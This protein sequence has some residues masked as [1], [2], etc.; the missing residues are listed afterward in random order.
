MIEN[1]SQDVP[2]C[3]GRDND[4][5]YF[6]SHSSYKILKFSAS[7]ITKANLFE[8]AP[9]QFWAESF[10]TNSKK[11]NAFD[12]DEAL[13]WLIQE[14][15]KSSFFSAKNLYGTGF[16]RDG[17]KLFFNT[18]ESVYFWGPEKLFS[19]D[20]NKILKY[21]YVK[22]LSDSD[23]NKTFLEGELVDIDI[24][25]S[26]ATQDQCQSLF[27]LIQKLSFENQ[28]SAHLLAGWIF[29][30]QVT[31]AMAWRP[32]IWVTGPAGS[33][34]TTI[35]RDILIP[36]I[37]HKKQFLGKTTEA[38][39]RQTI[40]ADSC[41]VFF[42]EAES[43]DKI[44]AQRVQNII[45]LVRASSSDSEAAIIKG[46]PSGSSIEYYPRF[47][48]CLSS[49]NTNLATEQDRSRFTLIELVKNPNNDF[50]TKTK[51]D[52]EKMINKDFANA[53]ALRSID[54]FRIFTLNFKKLY[55]LIMK[56]VSAR[57]ADQI[58]T[59]AAG[60]LAL[61]QDEIVRDPK[62]FLEAH[63]YFLPKQKVTLEDSNEMECLGH[64]LSSSVNDT[65]TM[66]TI[67]RLLYFVYQND[68][69]RDFAE[70]LLET[71][72]L[73]FNENDDAFLVATNHAQLAKIF[74]GTQ[75][76]KWGSS[77]SRIEGAKYTTTRIYGRVVCAVKIPFACVI[78]R[79]GDD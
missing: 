50:M 53:L 29:T 25:Q 5:Y 20:T 52:F 22:N 63:N 79:G 49:I 23:S 31:G 9:L 40:K 39:I 76:I 61:I 67:Q 55:P 58:G 77:L 71:L 54:N 21:K 68:G 30:A 73:K 66:Y 35:L 24:N 46:S 26:P 45:E 42:D 59:L 57:F 13:N 64:L 41:A 44:S 12:L 36:L 51:F 47:Q 33:G 38:G 17:Q 8:L 27:E 19:A 65:G 43:F 62:S 78:N 34:K 75:W 1:Q 28:S 6:R 14:G 72:G 15:K 11:I 74:A 56:K 7:K 37:F 69:Q 48:A 60:Y 70:K 32:H 4:H 18:G 10:Q 16:G 3:I 2:V